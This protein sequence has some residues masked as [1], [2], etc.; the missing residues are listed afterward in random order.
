MNRLK[1]EQ[2]KKYNAERQG[3][4][5]AQIQALNEKQAREE[6]L[7]QLTR[8][9]HVTWF[10]EE[11]DFMCDDWVDSQKRKQGIRFPDGNGHSRHQGSN[12]MS[13][14]YITAVNLRRS[15]FGIA[16]LEQNGLYHGN[17]S[18]LIAQREAVLRLAAEG[19]DVLD[20]PYGIDRI[21]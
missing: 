14:S 1:K 19:P 16:P 11:Y 8:H 6:R 18:W 2:V 12:P 13:A 20:K 4:S 3:L 7:H 10:P 9:I 15:A 17:D 21:K 5:L